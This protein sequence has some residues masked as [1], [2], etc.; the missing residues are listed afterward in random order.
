MRGWHLWGV[1]EGFID[2]HPALGLAAA[3]RSGEPLSGFSITLHLQGVLGLWPRG[4]FGNHVL[5]S[6]LQVMLRW[7]GVGLFYRGFFL[8]CLR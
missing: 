6:V 7:Q 2:W 1:C 5:H 8:F 4:L 3:L